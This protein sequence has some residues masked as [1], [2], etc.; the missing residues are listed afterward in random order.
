MLDSSR[1]PHMM[2]ND[3]TEPAKAV[4]TALRHGKLSVGLGNVDRSYDK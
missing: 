1:R 3:N 4:Q 2:F